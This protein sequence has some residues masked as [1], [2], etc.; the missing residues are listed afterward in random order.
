MARIIS[1]GQTVS[2]RFQHMPNSSF[3]T[4]L[5]ETRDVTLAP[6]AACW[7]LPAFFRHSLAVDSAITR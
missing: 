6:V 7:R 4:Q 2:Y 5:D 1:R 3:G